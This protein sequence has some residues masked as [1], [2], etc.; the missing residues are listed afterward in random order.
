MKQ[1]LLFALMFSAVA[2]AATPPA[3]PLP[4]EVPPTYTAGKICDVTYAFEGETKEAFDVGSMA[5]TLRA[6]PWVDVLDNHK[7]QMKVVDIMSKVQDKGGE[8]SLTLV[9]TNT[10]DGGNT[11]RIDE[12]SV[13]VTGVTLDGAVKVQD[14]ALQAQKEINDRYRGRAAKGAKVGWD[15]SKAQKVKR[16]DLGRKVKP[17][18]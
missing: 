4:T 1:S 2:W 15:H 8:Y 14:T 18:K 13:F 16:D 17:D 7:K 5:I 11:V 10:C 12:G 3:I 9:E 6:V